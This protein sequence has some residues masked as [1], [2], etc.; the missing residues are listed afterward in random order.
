MA[1]ICPQ[2]KFNKNPDRQTG[3]KNHFVGVRGSQNGYMHTKIPGRL[4]FDL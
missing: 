1:K 3:S 2:T 4:H